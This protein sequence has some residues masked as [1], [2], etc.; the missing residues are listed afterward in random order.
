MKSS[1]RILVFCAAVLLAGLSL[2]AQTPS[3]LEPKVERHQGPP[4]W[5][6]AE[7]VANEEK[8]IDLDLIG[9]DSLRRRVDK[10]RQALGAR[11]PAEKSGLGKKPEIARIPPS[12]CKSESY[13]E[14]YR[15]GDGPSATLRDLV[16]HSRSIVRGKIRTVEL[17][18]SFG[19]PSSLLG[20]ESSEVIKGAA[21]KSPFYVDY[22]VAR[23][24]I[25]PLSFCN[26]TKGFEPRSGDEILFFDVAGPVD[27]IDVLYVPRMDQIF[28]QSQSGALFLPPHLKNTA[29]LETAGSLADV[30]ARLRSG[31]LLNPPGDAR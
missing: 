26:A 22:P 10:Q 16:A 21:P 14:D 2:A 18:F 23:F 8:I 7:S 3:I 5:I 17:G 9:S 15:A 11:L 30:V 24:K 25:G 13:L 12:E 28:F 1:R 20:V 19:T 31:G 27:R 29:D 4:L 6:S